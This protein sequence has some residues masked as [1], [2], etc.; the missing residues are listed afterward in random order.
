M[1]QRQIQI[2]KLVSI[3][4]NIERIQQDLFGVAEIYDD[5][6]KDIS[7]PLYTTVEMLDEITKIVNRIKVII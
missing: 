7:T 6:H 4:S 3:S 2:R 5:N 1:N